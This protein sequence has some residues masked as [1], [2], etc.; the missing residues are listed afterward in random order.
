MDLSN[1]TVREGNKLMM[2]VDE[3][4]DPDLMDDTSLDGS[5]PNL[6]VDE[7]VDHS[8]HNDYERHSLVHIPSQAVEGILLLPESTAVVRNMGSTRAAQV[9]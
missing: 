1:Y 3:V 9:G 4:D 7:N 8:P 5:K 6:F 2:V